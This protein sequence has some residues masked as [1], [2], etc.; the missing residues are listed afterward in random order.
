MSYNI[1]LIFAI[2]LFLSLRFSCANRIGEPAHTSLFSEYIH[3]YG[4]LR[5]LARSP[6]HHILYNKMINYEKMHAQSLKNESFSTS[7]HRVVSLTSE[8]NNRYLVYTMS[9]NT[10][11]SSGMVSKSKNILFYF[12]NIVLTILGQYNVGDNVCVCSWN[13]HKSHIIN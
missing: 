2:S 9:D 7:F 12:Y 4:G 6:K 10:M 1:E 11:Y 13:S 3:T 8:I 5:Y